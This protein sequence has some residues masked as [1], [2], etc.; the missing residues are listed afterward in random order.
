MIQML[1][2]DLLSV[3]SIFILSQFF[4]F[5]KLST[6]A[7]FLEWPKPPKHTFMFTFYFS[8]FKK[9]YFLSST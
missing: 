4:T 6:K 2:Q 8:T 1:M 5:A 7:L 9:L 3:K